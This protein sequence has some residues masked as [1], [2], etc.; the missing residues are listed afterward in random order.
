MGFEPPV[1]EG[2]GVV[3]PHFSYEFHFDLVYSNGCARLKESA[4][5]LHVIGMGM[6]YDDNINVLQRQGE[7]SQMVLHIPE[8]VVM[9]RVHQY[10]FFTAE[11]IGV[12]IIGGWVQPG[13]RE[14]AIGDLHFP[15]F[16]FRNLIPLESQRAFLMEMGQNVTTLCP[17][18]CGIVR[19]PLRGCQ[20]LIG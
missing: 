2:L 20:P 19:R 12:T 11:E 3:G 16:S 7:A 18:L 13:K 15:L 4:N 17:A 6:G 8:E 5:G 9:A 14:N 10:A 1:S